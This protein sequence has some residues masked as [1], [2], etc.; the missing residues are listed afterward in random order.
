MPFTYS[1]FDA[2]C[3]AVSS[4]PTFT[5]TDYLRQTEQVPGM[6]VILRF[7][8]DYRESHAIH[9]AQ[10][11][12]SHALRG[13]FYFRHHATGFDLETIYNVAALGHE[14]GYHFET[15]D[16]CR[17]DFDRAG[18]LFVEHIAALRREGV[19]VSTVA[20]HG[21]P[22]ASPT[23]R[24]NRDLLVQQPELL[25][26][27]DI[28]GETTLSIDFS[29]VVYISDAYWHWRHYDIPAPGNM[30]QAITLSEA[31]E[32]CQ[33]RQTG[34]YVTFH[35]HQWFASPLSAT[36]YRWRQRIGAH[37]LPVVRRTR[38]LRKPKA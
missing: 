28:I 23:Y 14:V 22:P 10:L 32:A 29:R 12:H 11:A 25:T 21:S 17:G 18:A 34:L 30:G 19:Q 33:G 38:P 13:S 6:F 9:L 5:V 1:T 15:L 16:T 20:A 3:Q 31:L 35:P 8:V 24:S 2:F 27:A 7:D 4:K 37:V 26:Q 36:Y